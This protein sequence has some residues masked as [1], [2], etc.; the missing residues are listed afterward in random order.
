MIRRPPSS[1]MTVSLVALVLLTGT[2]AA[3]LPAANAH[4]QGCFDGQG[5]PQVV[6][7]QGLCGPVLSR[8]AAGRSR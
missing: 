2:T 5:V 4:P 6:D 1:R 8:T 7:A 3:S